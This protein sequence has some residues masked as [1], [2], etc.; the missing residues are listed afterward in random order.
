MSTHETLF[1][2]NEE[3]LHRAMTLWVLEQRTKEDFGAIEIIKLLHQYVCL[4]VQSTDEEL[5]H[6]LSLTGSSPHAGQSKAS[7][8]TIKQSSN[9]V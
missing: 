3:F 9:N 2:E 8:Q 7:H 1:S 5:Q 4:T 6:Y